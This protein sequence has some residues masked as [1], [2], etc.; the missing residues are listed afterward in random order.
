[1]TPVG[2]LNYMHQDPIRAG[3]VGKAHHFIYSFAS[4]YDE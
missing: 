3:I 2:K 1:M 4:N